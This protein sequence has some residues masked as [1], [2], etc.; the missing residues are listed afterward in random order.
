MRKEGSRSRSK[1][2]SAGCKRGAD[3]AAERSQ[4]LHP[5]KFSGLPFRLH[6]R[7]PRR[8]GARRGVDD[9][10]CIERSQAIEPRAL[11]DSRH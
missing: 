5:K 8:E 4:L 10:L 11:G 6:F 7:H 2:T 3:A 1:V 9:V